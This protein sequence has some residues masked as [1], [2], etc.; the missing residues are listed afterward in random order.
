MTLDIALRLLQRLSSSCPEFLR[1]EV[2]QNSQSRLC[3]S[4]FFPLPS[5]RSLYIYRG[6]EPFPASCHELDPLHSFGLRPVGRRAIPAMGMWSAKQPSLHK[7][8]RSSPCNHSSFEKGLINSSGIW[9]MCQGW[10]VRAPYITL[11]AHIF[12]NGFVQSYDFSIAYFFYYSGS[13]FPFEDF[14]QTNL[15]GGLFGVLPK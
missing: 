14:A 15:P 8:W 9:M 11:N 10:E 12:K 2:A 4:N 7:T 1:R 13:F 5:L 6:P 3:R